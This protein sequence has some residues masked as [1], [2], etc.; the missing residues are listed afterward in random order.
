MAWRLPLLLADQIILEGGGGYRPGELSAPLVPALGVLPLQR[1]DRGAPC[2]AGE[3]ERPQR[4][5]HALH[6]EV[7]DGGGAAR[8]EGGLVVGERG[9]LQ[10]VEGAE[11]HAGATARGVPDLGGERAP[12]PR[13]HP[14]EGMRAPLLLP[15]E[16]SSSFGCRSRLSTV[17]G[18]HTIPATA[19]GLDKKD[20]EESQSENSLAQAATPP[21]S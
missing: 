1:E 16:A 18:L 5:P 9:G 11:P 8:G 19:I 12:R 17:F 7:E 21:T 6:G 14:D 15:G 13:A 3:R 4:L 10:G 2:A 20:E